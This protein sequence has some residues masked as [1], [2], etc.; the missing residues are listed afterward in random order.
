MK[1]TLTHSLT[2]LS[3]DTEVLGP[4]GDLREPT[5]IEL[6]M[7]SCGFVEP[8]AM[9]YLVAALAS[10][11]TK[12]RVG[13]FELELPAS[14]DVRGFLRRWRFGSALERV[15]SLDHRRASWLTERSQEYRDA[16]AETV[17][18]Y[19]AAR[20]SGPSGDLV[21]LTSL[22]FFTTRIHK[23]DEMALDV[24]Q[25][26]ERFADDQRD[27]WEDPDI[28]AILERH[29]GRKANLIAP[30]VIYEAILNSVFHPNADTVMVVSHLNTQSTKK[31]PD[32]LLTISFWDNGRSVTT[33]IRDT[34][35]SGEE[36]RGHSLPAYYDWYAI[37]R[38][39]S[40]KKNWKHESTVYSGDWLPTAD[41]KDHSL[42]VVSTFPGVSTAHERPTAEASPLGRSWE[43]T[44]M[45]LYILTSIVVDSFGGELAIRSG[46]GFANVKRAVGFDQT[47]LRSRYRCNTSLQPT[48][49]L[50]LAGTQL[51]V[52]I[53]LLP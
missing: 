8:A 38:G 22:R 51:T 41:G 25:T 11:K 31:Y 53:P 33:T 34:L 6:D 18:P 28:N 9:L 35:K 37:Y 44:G 24:D 47:E 5:V 42:L 4:L 17:A 45:G 27:M 14:A 30:G 21:E 20:R 1:I 32:G 10:A 49:A 23:L 26:P 46:R 13:S 19:G 48:K 36:L 12:G 15:L 43:K 39:P 52:R 3:V 16:D 2:T 40:G 29:L 50:P 7:S